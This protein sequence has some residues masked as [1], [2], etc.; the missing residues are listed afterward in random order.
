[1]ENFNKQI[2]ELNFH[3]SFI[4]SVCLSEEGILKVKFHYYN[5]EGNEFKSEQWTTKI[6]TIEIE[7]CVHLK[8]SSPGLWLEDQEIQNHEC[9]DKHSELVQQIENYKERRK[10]DYVNTIAVRFM[11]HSYGEPIFNESTGFLEIGGLNAKLVWS[12]QSEVGSPIHIP[13]GEKK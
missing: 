7:H 9:L 3:D 5:W 11:T 6:L 2:D 1:M 4:D 12:E 13:A 8:F 10:S